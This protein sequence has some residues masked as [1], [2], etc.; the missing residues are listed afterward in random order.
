MKSMTPKNRDNIIWKELS[1]I[2][3]I[4]ERLVSAMIYDDFGIYCPD[5]CIR[6]WKEE[7]SLTTSE[8]RKEARKRNGGSYALYVPKTATRHD[9]GL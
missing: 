1:K 4:S 3:R 7:L 5:G 8:T 6:T 2:S 9:T